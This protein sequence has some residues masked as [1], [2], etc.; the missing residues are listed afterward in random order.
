MSRYLLVFV[1]ASLVFAA[2]AIGQER[3]LMPVDEASQDSSFLAFRTKLIAAAEQKDMKYVLSIL[4]PKIEVSYGGYSGV[5]GFRKMWIGKK[6]AEFWKEFLPVI[7][8]GGK[9]ERGKGAEPPAF[10]APYVFGTFPED[11]D[12]FTDAAVFG[13]NVNLR[14]TPNLNARVVAKL[15]YNLVKLDY[16]NS[17]KAKDENQTILWSKVETFGGLKGFVKPEFLRSPIDYRGG[18]QKKRGR[19]VMTFF[20]AGD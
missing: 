11:L 10:S 7:K 3:Y 19:W 17:I 4:D 13:T 5:S 14:E 18:F 9:Y 15:S 1:V 20:I 2:A 12:M 8:N 16:E 6:E